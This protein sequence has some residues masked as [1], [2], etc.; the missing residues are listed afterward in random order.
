MNSYYTLTPPPLSFVS[1]PCEC[2]KQ[3]RWVL[4]ALH[5]NFMHHYLFL[6]VSWAQ[7]G[8]KVSC[9][10]HKKGHLSRTGVKRNQA[11]IC[12][13]LVRF[14]RR[15]SWLYTPWQLRLREPPGHVR[16]PVHVPHLEPAFL[17]RL[18][19]LPWFVSMLCF[20]IQQV[21]VCPSKIGPIWICQGITC[22][23]MGHCEVNARHWRWGFWRG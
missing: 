18:S 6:F 20:I 19:C 22:C 10:K 3:E 21:T 11:V 4:W 1:C 2:S 16:V 7:E 8:C 13:N 23:W 15:S 14:T 17:L 5:H 9:W 12:S